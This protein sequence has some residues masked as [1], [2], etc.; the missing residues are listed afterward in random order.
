MTLAN[1]P[2]YGDIDGCTS[3]N[4]SVIDT[5]GSAGVGARYRTRS[6]NHP[7]EPTSTLSSIGCSSIIRRAP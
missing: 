7:V 4:F 5:N 2:P 1:F 6:S 3:I